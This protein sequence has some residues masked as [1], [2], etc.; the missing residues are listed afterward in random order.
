MTFCPE[1]FS[2]AITSVRFLSSMSSLMLSHIKGISE[3]LVT[4]AAIALLFPFIYILFTSRY[5]LFSSRCIC[6]GHFFCKTK[7]TSTVK[8][9]NFW[10][11]ENFAVIYLKFKKTGQTFGFFVKRCKR[12]SKQ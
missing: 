12:Y 5:F 11:P 9:L 1:G 4:I 3:G 7:T 2:T 10:M 6:L 8:F